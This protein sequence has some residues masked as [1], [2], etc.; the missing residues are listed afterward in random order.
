MGELCLIDPRGSAHFYGLIAQMRTSHPDKSQL[1]FLAF[2]LLHL[3]SVDLRG[4][5]AIR[6]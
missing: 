1:M 3:D 4:L 2:D 5:P 6:A